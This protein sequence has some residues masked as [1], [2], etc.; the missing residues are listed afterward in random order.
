LY[1]ACQ[2][3][4]IRRLTVELEEHRVANLDAIDLVGERRC[5]ELSGRFPWRPFRPGKLLENAPGEARQL[6]VAF[7]AG[8][9]R[10]A[11]GFAIPRGS[12]RLVP[13]ARAD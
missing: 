12:G 7:K 9:G 5:H 11:A 10:S 13:A 4:A 1:S 3:D 6:R 2:S 8:E